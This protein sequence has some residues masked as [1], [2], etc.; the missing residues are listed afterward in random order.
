VRE[1]IDQFLVECTCDG[2]D[3]GGGDGGGFDFGGFD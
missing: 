1:G 2:F 3:F